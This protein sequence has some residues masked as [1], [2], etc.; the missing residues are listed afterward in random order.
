[1]GWLGTGPFFGEKACFSDKRLAEN[2]DLSPSRGQGGQSHFRGGQANSRRNVLLAAKIGTVPCE[3]LH[4]GNPGYAPCTEF[5]ELSAGKQAIRMIEENAVPGAYHP[6][7]MLTC[8]F[9]W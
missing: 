6:P 7:K 1:M 9:G 2:M 4:L 5:R 8:P 3:R